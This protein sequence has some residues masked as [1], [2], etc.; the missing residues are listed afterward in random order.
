MKS[1]REQLWE[2]I[3]RVFLRERTKKE[4]AAQMAKEHGTSELI[5]P[6]IKQETAY[7]NRLYSRIAPKRRRRPVVGRAPAPEH[8]HDYIILALFFHLYYCFSVSQLASHNFYDYKINVG[9][10]PFCVKLA[11]TLMKNNIFDSILVRRREG[12]Q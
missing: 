4:L 9:I 8:I 12:L 5:M 11:P 7:I 3:K 10:Y 6:P 2:G 1:V